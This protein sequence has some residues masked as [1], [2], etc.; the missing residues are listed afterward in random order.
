VRRTQDV[1]PRA[2]AAR[3]IPSSYRPPQIRSHHFFSPPGGGSF[4]FTRIGS[5]WPSGQRREVARL[6]LLPLADFLAVPIADS[7]SDRPRERVPD[8]VSPLEVLS[9]RRFL[10]DEVLGEVRLVVADVEARHE[11]VRSAAPRLGRFV[12]PEDPERLQLLAREWIGGA[13]IA[14]AHVPGV[15]EKDRLHPLAAH[16]L[17]EERL[18]EVA[19]VLFDVSGDVLVGGEPDRPVIRRF[20]A[21]A[22]RQGVHESSCGPSAFAI[23][24]RIGA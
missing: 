10:E 7:A 5:S 22:P 2:F 16:L 6:L 11:D 18:V 17:G 4:N 3:G 13:R 14:P 20:H 8:D 23:P 21:A 1:I 24:S 15:L 9:V 19:E 12:Q